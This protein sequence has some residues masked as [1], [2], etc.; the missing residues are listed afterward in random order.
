MGSNNL[1]KDLSLIAKFAAGGQKGAG[2][3]EVKPMKVIGIG[4]CRTGTQSLLAAFKRL[5]A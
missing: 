3:A 2:D 4:F 1:A 5:G